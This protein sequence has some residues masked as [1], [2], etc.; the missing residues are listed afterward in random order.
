MEQKRGE[1]ESCALIH[2]D[3]ESPAGKES[4]PLK[5]TGPP[6][7]NRGH[8]YCGAVWKLFFK[9]QLSSF[10]LLLYS[11]LRWGFT[12]RNTH[13]CICSQISIVAII[14]KVVKMT[15]GQRYGLGPQVWLTG[16][17]NWFMGWVR[18]QHALTHLF[19]KRGTLQGGTC[20]RENAPWCRNSKAHILTN[21]FTVLTP[22]EGAKYINPSLLDWHWWA[23]CIGTDMHALDL[24][25]WALLHPTSQGSTPASGP[26][27]DATTS[28]VTPVG[29]NFWILKVFYTT[30]TPI[31]IYSII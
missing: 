24:G 17:R 28:M 18:Q 8:L 15:P 7:T 30:H 11:F 20:W 31:S 25:T 4:C 12:K 2:W 14:C 1:S 3:E 21:R 9:L 27:L 22:K 19:C 6:K 23:T 5:V 10:I 13:F 29:S 26:N 16:S